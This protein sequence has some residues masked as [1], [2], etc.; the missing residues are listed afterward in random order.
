[1][2]KAL[3]RFG[4]AAEESM[5]KEL[6]QLVDKDVFDN[7]RKLTKDQWKSVIRSHMFLKEK[8]LADGSFGKLKSRFVAGGDMQDKSNYE[9]ISSSTASSQT[10]TYSQSLQLRQLKKE[11]SKLLATFRVHI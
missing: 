7:F 11:L 10:V 4:K 6:Q 1:V 3:S 2:K 9:D 5:E 8:H